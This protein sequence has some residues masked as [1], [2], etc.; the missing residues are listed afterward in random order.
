M[1]GGCFDGEP[2]ALDLLLQ[3]VMAGLAL[4]QSLKLAADGRAR[5]HPEESADITL[6]HASMP[7]Q[8]LRRDGTRHTVVLTPAECGCFDPELRRHDIQNGGRSRGGRHTPERYVLLPPRP[9]SLA[10][11]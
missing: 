8:Q 11:V 7:A 4:A 10:R 5:A 6:I 9:N 2:Y 3:R 1:L